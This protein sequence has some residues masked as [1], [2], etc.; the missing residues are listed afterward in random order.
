MVSGNLFL[1][2]DTPVEKFR[3]L[4]VMWQALTTQRVTPSHYTLLRAEIPHLKVLW[5][6]PINLLLVHTIKGTQ[7]IGSMRYF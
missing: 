6:V 1:S 7:I 4:A 5:Q 2:S 3:V